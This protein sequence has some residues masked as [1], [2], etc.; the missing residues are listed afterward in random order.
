MSSGAK[1]H[2]L[3]HEL[4]KFSFD[5][6]QKATRDFFDKDNI[7]EASLL[8]E[9]T[10][11]EH[12]NKELKVSSARKI[13]TLANDLKRFSFDDLRNA[14]RDFDNEMRLGGGE[15]GEVYEGWIDAST[16]SPSIVDGLLRIAIKRFYHS[17]IRCRLKEK[18]TNLTFFYNI[19]TV[20]LCMLHGTQLVHGLL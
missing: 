10:I 9:H 13:N 1:T 14:T 20:E 8:E 12:T 7:N 2:T 11:K 4:K 6:Q 15:F 19:Y 3:A 5:D 16:S 17:K 18:V